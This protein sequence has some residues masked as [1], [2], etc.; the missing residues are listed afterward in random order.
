[1]SNLFSQPKTPSPENYSAEDIEILEGLEPVRH[2]PG[3]YIGGTDERALHHLAA[4]VIDN[5]MD[6]A[7]AGYATQIHLHLHADH[8]LAIQDN[9]RGIPVEPHPKYPERSALEIILTT[10][11]AGGKFKTGAYETAGGLH[12][13]GLSVV[14]ALSASLKVDVV[15]NKQ[16]WSQYYSKGHPQTPLTCTEKLPFKKGTRITFHPDKEIFGDHASFKAQTLYKLARSKAY[17][18]KG[19]TIYWSCDPI[20]LTDDSA[21]PAEETLHYPE[22]LVDHLK[23]LV[24]TEQ[25]LFPLTYEGSLPLPDNQG[26]I[27]WAI[28]WA[29]NKDGALSSY[30]NTIPTP[31][32][33][34]HENAFKNTLL[35]SLKAYGEVAKNKK[36]FLITTDDLFRSAFALL[37]VFIKDPQFQGQTKEKLASA[38]VSKLIENTLRDHFDHWLVAHHNDAQKLLE[39]TIEKAEIRQRLKAYK[40][41]Q[42]KSVTQRL[43]LPGKLADCARQSAEGTEL[44]VVEG[45]SAGGSAKQARD[46][47]TQAILPLRGKILNVASATPEK[48][49]ASQEIQNLIQALG[50]GVGTHLNLDKL[51]YERIIIMTDADVD[52]AHIASLLLTFFYQAMRPLIQQGHLFLAQPPL[53]R[54]KGGNQVIYVADDQAKTK[55]LR[56][57]FPKNAKVEISRFKGLGEM[58]APQL[59]ETTMSPKHRSLI[60]VDLPKI[61]EID[62]TNVGRFVEELMGRQAE[63]RYEYIQQNARFVEDLDI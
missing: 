15:R 61:H 17:L 16:L 27:E 25:L 60:R 14:N 20:F 45:D 33:G 22:G 3:M 54:L 26:R 46:R 62:D 53:Y 44:F 7:V 2:R 43:R 40:E 13:V 6:E 1:M 19:V 9:G 34:T 49:L 41:T 39:H 4:E 38:H 5:A 29:E 28:L 32:G 24:A 50:C 58:S 57:M 36:S 12:G 52:G 30:C 23:T 55:A 59:K 56:T 31:L 11:H 8:T 48:I 47:Q 63:K 10:L 51:R 42:R 37:S 21:V 18:F 35:K